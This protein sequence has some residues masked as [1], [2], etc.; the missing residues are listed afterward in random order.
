MRVPGLRS[1]FGATSDEIS[2]TDIVMLMTPHIV[3]THELTVEDLAPIYIGTQQN[4][5]LTGPPPLIR[6]AG[7]GRRPLP[8][9]RRSGAAGGDHD[10]DAAVPA[11]ARRGRRCPPRRRRLPSSDRRHGAA[12]VPP[13]R[14]SRR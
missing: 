13:H 5:G 14:R 7:R 6:A 4:V 1:L 9:R 2:Q 3:R 10:A 11:A 12:A 8:R